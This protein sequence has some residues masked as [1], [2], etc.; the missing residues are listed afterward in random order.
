VLPPVA[1]VE[2]PAPVEVVEEPTEESL[3]PMEV[4]EA[5]EPVV[6]APP[7]PAAAPVAPPRRVL[8]PATNVELPAE[9]VPVDLEPVEEI[10][11]LSL[12][13]EQP[14]LPAAEEEV[15]EE[16][17]GISFEPREVAE[18][19]AHS[20]PELPPQVVSATIDELIGAI[21]IEEIE[22]VAGKIEPAP[23]PAASESPITGLNLDVEDFPEVAAAAEPEVSAGAGDEVLEAPASGGE[24]TL[25]LD[26]AL[27]AA[28]AAEVGDLSRGATENPSDTEFGKLVEQFSG[29]STGPLVEESQFIGASEAQTIEPETREIPLRATTDEISIAPAEAKIGFVIDSPAP[30]PIRP[31]L[32]PATVTSDSF[33]LDDGFFSADLTANGIFIREGG[34]PIG[35]ASPIVPMQPAA[36]RMERPAPMAP[37]APATPA[38]PS[39]PVAP[40]APVKPVAP[41]VTGW[42]STPETIGTE[43]YFGGMPVD[44][45]QPKKPAG[46]PAQIS[47]AFDPKPHAGEK[48]GRAARQPGDVDIPQPPPKARSKRATPF[49]TKSMGIS[50]EE[51]EPPARPS[52]GAGDNIIRGLSTAFDGLAMPPRDVFSEFEATASNDAAFGGVRLSRGDDY[53]LPE[54]PEVAARLSNTPD[55]DFAED[56]FWNRTDEE[57]GALPTGGGVGPS[58]MEP[59][60]AE[61]VEAEPQSLEP[62]EIE[63]PT[64]GEAPRAEAAQ[65]EAGLEEISLE[66]APTPVVEPEPEPAALEEPAP[67]E[68]E[69]PPVETP[70]PVEVVRKTKRVAPPVAAAPVKDESEETWADIPVAAAAPADEPATEEAR[71]VEEPPAAVQPPPK[72]PRRAVSR[73]RVLPILMLTMLLCMGIVLAGI[74]LLI[75]PKSHVVGTLTYVN[76]DWVPGTDDGAQFEA[77]QRRILESDETHGHAREVLAQRFPGT[78]PGFLDTDA[79]GYLRIVSGVKL[80]S[81]PMNGQ[82]QTMLQ[83]TADGADKNR[84]E[85]RMGALLQAVYD[86]NAA[87]VDDNRRIREIATGANQEVDDANQRIVEIKAQMPSLQRVIDQNPDPAEFAA[88]TLR[89]QQLQKARFDAE[90]VLDQ[91]REGLERL[92]AAGAQTAAD[93]PQQQAA[94]DPQLEALRQQILALNKQLQDAKDQQ[95]AGVAEARSQLEQAVQQ[96]NDQLSASDG[97]LDSGSQLR[98]FVDSAKDSQLKARQM[99]TTLIV[100]GEDLQRQL[101]DTRRDVEEMIQSRQEEK[102]AGDPQLQELQTSLDGAQHRYNAAVG[103]GV[104]DQQLLDSLKKEIDDLTAQV[105]AR[106]DALGVDPGEVK[107]ADGLNKVIESQRRKLEKEKQQIDD[108]L[109]PLE[110]Q[111]A[112]L[113]GQVGS[114]PEAQQQMA[115][116]LRQSLSG[117][118]EA[119]KNYAQMLGEGESAPSAKVTDLEKQVDDLKSRFDRRQA[120]L[121]QQQ[122]QQDASQLVEAQN[123]FK[124]DKDGLEETKKA[125]DAVRVQYDDEAGRRE[126][127]QAAQAQMEELTEELNNRSSELEVAVRDRDQKQLQADRCFDI[128]PPTDA[129]VLATSVDPRQVYSLYAM[130]GLAVLFTLLT[131]AAS[132]RAAERRPGRGA[133]KMGPAT[134]QQDADDDR[135]ALPA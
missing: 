6:V 92:Q 25:D 40:A 114:L 55:H 126:D 49:A 46:K 115:Q 60:A 27:P 48:A 38:P 35:Q 86:A 104:G 63:P 1:K 96:F 70:T 23:E 83:L 88:L 78:T 109:D 26:S 122:P 11:P 50:P 58:R 91:D 101:E 125:Y 36:P 3:P 81:S 99:I 59:P 77:S 13:P 20:E 94:P 15:V 110:Q 79:A 39:V 24:A 97:V 31:A 51:D 66:D 17:I 14:V 21:E 54:S 111:L 37:A 7:P 116:Q 16:P 47:V 22:S 72:A 30:A 89:K 52:K 56:D 71:I 76:F 105:K 95:S 113:D 18:P 73:T 64:N 133:G 29:E 43:S 57:E 90:D 87:T 75:R 42:N 53:V 108:V 62:T 129:D 128:R 67:P 32:P 19:E 93:P 131:I 84:D 68:V 4:V 117:L 28:P 130:G 103:E 132:R 102:W 34:K 135:H 80:S 98:Q 100:D 134:N 61:P 112:S 82:S 85:Q 107:V 118:N 119:R 33:S 12:E 120:D 10:A 124:L 45:A 5:E 121:A 65:P 9:D 41:A 8:P 44:L 2:S 127:A 123:Q 69:P 106:K 74:W